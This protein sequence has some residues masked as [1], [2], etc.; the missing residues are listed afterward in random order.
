ME[1][2]L[3]ALFAL[4]AGFG[5]AFSPCVLPVLPLV[6]SGGASGGRRRP[7]G[8]AVGLAASFAFA[9]LALAYV[10]AALGLPDDLL[11]TVAIVVLLA[12]G[13]SL[14]LPPVAA[15]LEGLI[16]RLV[17]V[18]AASTEGEGF[19]SGVVLG[20]SL[21]LLYVPCAGPILAA[22]LTVSASQALSAQR[23]VTGLAYA[24]GTATGVLI[25]SVAGRRLLARWRANSGRIQQGLGLVM[26]LFAVLTLTGADD[27][28]RTEIASA[29]PS[30]L[31]SPTE[32]LE[33]SDAATKALGRKVRKSGL[34]DA[35]PA[36]EIAG[37]QKWFNS[38][39]L[40]LRELR[41]RVVLIDFWTYTCINCIRTQPHLKA[42]DA[43]YRDDGLTIIGVHSPEFPFEKD[44]GNVER[45]VRRAGLEYP[46][47][48]DNDLS[49][50]SAFQNQYWP[51]EY[52]I[53]A[54][55]HLRYASFGEGEYEQ[56][57]SAI[58][59]LL[60]EAGRPARPA[61]APAVHAQT[62]SQGMSTP[63]TY[64]GSARAQGFLQ[65]PIRSGVHAFAL[66]RP[67]GLGQDVF[68][69]G[70]V[71]RIGPEA[72][73]AGSG[74]RVA[75]RFGARRVFLV[76]GSPGRPRKVEVRL[77]GA[78]PRTIT[79]DHQDIYTLADL[80]RVE[81]RYLELRLEPGVQAY[82]FTFG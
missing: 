80:P 53:D 17:P 26:V 51:A 42:W 72:A 11:R 7:L 60:R 73:T 58:K 63:E 59:S 22:V 40:T 16:S 66:P 71:W 12:F 29:L 52:L 45:A 79:V 24:V 70:G 48:Q 82:A 74:A 68:A 38:K 56:T 30:W 27:R 18:R 55:G 37:T 10:I 76:L 8:I 33:Q 67:G 64:L 75:V 5:T 81:S 77:Q 14:V 34:Q 2:V 44:A 20:A 21:G 9:T 32:K 15:R 43:R 78:A 54:R 49:V 23:L 57:E 25:L 61:S 46:V 36:P 4:I 35:G 13:V 31:V 41:G 62:P 50:W 69:L 39:P 6:L 3:A 19:G 28:F 47:A 1:F 65:D